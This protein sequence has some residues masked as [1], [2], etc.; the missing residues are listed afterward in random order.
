MTR[1]TYDPD[2]EGVCLL[3]GGDEREHEDYEPCMTMQIM[4]EDN[5]AIHAGGKHCMGGCGKWLP[6]RHELGKRA[7]VDHHCGTKR[8][9]R[10][11]CRLADGLDLLEVHDGG[12]SIG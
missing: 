3:C 6:T 9:V 8:C 7:I 10:Q 4:A 5:A 11:L 1:C 12:L 2:E